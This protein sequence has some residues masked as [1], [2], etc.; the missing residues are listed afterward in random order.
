MTTPILYAFL[1][2][3]I[4]IIGLIIFQNQRINSVN[5]LKNYSHELLTLATLKLVNSKYKWSV[6]FRN[7]DGF[8]LAYEHD[9]LGKVAYHIYTCYKEQLIQKQ[10]SV[11]IRNNLEDKYLKIIADG[12]SESMIG[13]DHPELGHIGY[14][15]FVE[16][17]SN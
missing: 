6:V 4:V 1:V 17:H 12:S 15:N 11:Y 8:K 9:D 13:V 16:L 7:L 14:L 2:G 10:M 5:H 3:V